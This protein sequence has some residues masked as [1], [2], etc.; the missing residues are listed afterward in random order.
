MIFTSTL[1]LSSRVSCH[2]SRHGAQLC[3]AK[4]PHRT[5]SR[6]G[7][8]FTKLQTTTHQHYLQPHYYY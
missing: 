7:A 6:Q 8:S 2:P 4:E 1:S 3:D 5:Q